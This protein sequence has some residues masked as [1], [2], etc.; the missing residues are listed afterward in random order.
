MEAARGTRSD[1]GTAS[2]GLGPVGGWW[3]RGWRPRRLT[4]AVVLW[5]VWAACATALIVPTALWARRA[6][7]VALA[8]AR[9]DVTHATASGAR[10]TENVLGL[11]DVFLK[12]LSEAAGDEGL[13][14]ATVDT[15]CPSLICSNNRRTSPYLLMAFTRANGE[16][17]VSSPDLPQVN[18]ADR[19]YFVAQR[20][21]DAGLFVGAPRRT[22]F[23]EGMFLPLSRRL[24]T[25]DGTFDG[26]VAAAFNTDLIRAVFQGQGIGRLDRIRLLGAEG[27]SLVDWSA[28]TV[29]GGPAKVDRVEET[30]CGPAGSR[31]TPEALTSVVKLPLGGL[32][33]EACRSAENALRTWRVEVAW[34][35]GCE[36]VLLLAAA[37][38]LPPASRRR[39]ARLRQQMG[40]RGLVAGS[41]DVQFI[42]AAKPDGRFVLEALTFS[43]GGELGRMSVRLIGRT[44]RDFFSPEDADLIEA[45]YRSVLASGHTRRTERRVRLGS[46]E[47]TWSTVLVPLA[48][49]GAHGGYIFGAATELVGTA[50]GELEGGLRRFTEDVLRREDGERR[51]IARELHDTTGQNLIAAG[52]ELGGVARGLV[53]ASPQVLAALAQARSLIDA[54]V[55]ELRTLAYVLHPALLDEAGL[56]LAL[57]TLAEGFESR[58]NVRVAVVIADG[59]MSRRWPAE[60]EL[61]LYRVAQEALTNVQRHSSTREAQVVLR[62]AQPGHLEL[63]VDNGPCPVPDEGLNGSPIVEGVG[64]RGMRDRLEVLGGTLEIVRRR[65]GLQV[66]ARVPSGTWDGQA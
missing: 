41:S 63:V 40:L 32:S 27:H 64:I 61:A 36:A 13:S 35:A 14:G 65:R 16:V 11:V 31:P 33:V 24:A 9:D 29:E 51:R 2:A 23:I 34:A 37:L 39:E 45:D 3:P 12:R 54:S 50:D 30:A 8:A 44:T 7:D 18:L 42:I 53:D 62:C 55:T 10:A 1:S 4:K 6:H 17:V 25:K 49:E 15:I 48:D 59:L 28:A 26:I 52:L 21:K 43:R 47:L 58:S 66:V 20:E 56:G 38:A 60:V 5:M 19:D 22:P 46:S 57:T